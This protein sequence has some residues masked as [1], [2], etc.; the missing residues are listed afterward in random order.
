[1]FW[2]PLADVND[3]EHGDNVPYGPYGAAVLAAGNCSVM[4]LPA[5][6]FTHAL[7]VYWVSTN[8]PVVDAESCV[9]V[10]LAHPVLG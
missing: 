5:T 4:A 7:S 8:V 1:M 2:T 3:D 10:A 9:N 6:A